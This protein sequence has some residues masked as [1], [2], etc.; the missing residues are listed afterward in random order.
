VN[1]AGVRVTLHLRNL[2]LKT[3]LRSLQEVAN[4]DHG[5]LQKYAEHLE[6]RAFNLQ[7][8]EM[9]RV[10]NDSDA[11]DKSAAGVQTFSDTGTMTATISID[12]SA[13]AMTYT[14]G[15]PMQIATSIS[16]SSL[17]AREW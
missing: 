5:H 8:E 9:V 4:H 2:R 15:E 7:H 3:A 1:R 16:S 14:C 12:S 11:A 17:T 6:L 10:P 13:M